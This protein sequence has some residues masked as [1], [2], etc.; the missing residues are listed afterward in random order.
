MLKLGS[1]HL[2]SNYDLDDFH[3]IGSCQVFLGNEILNNLKEVEKYFVVTPYFF[4]TFNIED[5]KKNS[6]VLSSWAY[7]WC[8]IN[9]KRKKENAETLIL[10]WKDKNVQVF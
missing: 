6:L 1:Y 2:G 7:L 10:T 3:N 8:L 5:K 9:I 4:L